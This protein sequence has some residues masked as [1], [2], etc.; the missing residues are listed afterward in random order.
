MTNVIDIPFYR[1]RR[2]SVSCRLGRFMFQSE[3][4]VIVLTGGSPEVR[5]VGSKNDQVIL[6]SETDC[7]L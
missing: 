5:P 1:P 4:Q 2:P 7:S 6:K 3:L